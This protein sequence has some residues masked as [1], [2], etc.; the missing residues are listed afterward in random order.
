MDKTKIIRIASLA[1]MALSAIATLVSEYA[2]KERQKET[3]KK[4][5]T[6]E[7]DRRERKKGES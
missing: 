3:I 2:D 7:L 1:G 6:K 5:I 4:E